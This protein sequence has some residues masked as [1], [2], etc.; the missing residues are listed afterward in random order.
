[1]SRAEFTFDGTSQSFSYAPTLPAIRTT[2]LARVPSWMP[3]VLATRNAEKP[4]EL[5]QSLDPENR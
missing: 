2:S 1:V 5:A 4:M 3:F